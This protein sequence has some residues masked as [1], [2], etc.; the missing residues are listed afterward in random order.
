MIETMHEPRDPYEHFVG[1]EDIE[2][3][4]ATGEAVEP[5]GPSFVI[6]QVTGV[7]YAGLGERTASVAIPV[8]DKDDFMM[9]KPA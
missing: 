1:E 2:P 4:A 3:D 7:P 6:R 8:F 9:T 5:Q